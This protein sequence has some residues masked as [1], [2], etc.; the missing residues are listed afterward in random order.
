M[1]VDV[2]TCIGFKPG[3]VRSIS[4]PWLKLNTRAPT[5]FELLLLTVLGT[6]IYPKFSLLSGAMLYMYHE[7]EN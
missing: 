6:Q 5:F 1:Q 4:R 2:Y 3:I 7:C